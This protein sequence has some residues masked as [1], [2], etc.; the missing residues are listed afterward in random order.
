MTFFDK[1]QRVVK[2]IQSRRHA[3]DFEKFLGDRYE[4]VDTLKADVAV[5]YDRIAKRL[6]VTKRRD[7]NSLPIYRTLK[8][9]DNPHVPKI[10][11]LFERDEKLIVIEEHVDGQ[12]LEDFLIYRPHEIDASFVKKF[13]LQVCDC[14]AAVHAKNI[15]HRDIKP[16]NI[17]LTENHFVKLVDFGIARLF[18]PESDADTCRLGTRDFA[19]P[20]QFGLFNF[21]QT[22]PRSDIYSLGV[23]LKLLGDHGDERLKKI[24]DKCTAFEPAQRFQS[25]EELLVQLRID[26][27]L[28]LK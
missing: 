19:P 5:V 3:T 24:L 12:T 25:V 9:L 4:H 16:A 11:R 10:Y 15:I 27:L 1:Y 18:K 23:T 22:D 7:L 20:E 14:L 28:T 21:G 17:M 6:C 13:L 26:K 2:E 8:A